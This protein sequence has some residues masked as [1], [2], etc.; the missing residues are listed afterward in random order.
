MV[1]KNEINSVMDLPEEVVGTF[2]QQLRVSNGSMGAMTHDDVVR[3]VMGR[4]GI[5]DFKEGVRICRLVIDECIVS[6]NQFNP[7]EE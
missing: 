6:N 3:A 7:T 1:T 2:F 4:L 5:T